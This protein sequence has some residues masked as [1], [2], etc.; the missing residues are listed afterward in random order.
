[1]STIPELLA[2]G[3]GYS[4]SGD[5]GEV[6]LGVPRGSVTLEESQVLAWLVRGLDVLEIGTGTGLSTRF[7]S[8]TAKT[9]F[10]VD[11]DPFV[12]E[13]VAPHL[14]SNVIFSRS[15]PESG[16]F[17]AVFV[18]GSH[19]KEACTSDLIFALKVVKFP[20]LIIVHDL[21]LPGPR[22]A[23]NNLIPKVQNLGTHLSLGVFLV[24]K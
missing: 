20:G 21:H 18:D 14:P 8:T 12:A 5:Q 17:D 1:M 10:T 11:P 19:T 2:Y 22:E 23:C 9:I 6:G 24:T 4:A 16:K 3:F 7:M 15:L 13:S